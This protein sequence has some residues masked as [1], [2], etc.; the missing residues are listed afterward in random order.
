MIFY[1]DWWAAAAAAS[2][3]SNLW[4][5]WGGQSTKVTIP[6]KNSEWFEPRSPHAL[7]LA[8]S[9]DIVALHDIIFDRIF[10]RYVFTKEDGQKS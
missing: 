2:A 6:E 7:H 10:I 3:P 4:V 5:N 1:G 8:H 9:L